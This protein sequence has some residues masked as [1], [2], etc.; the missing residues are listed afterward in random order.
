MKKQKL[1]KYKK[2]D[3]WHL[4]VLHFQQQEIDREKK[5]LGIWEHGQFLCRGGGGG[6]GFISSKIQSQTH[7][8][9]Q[10]LD[11]VMTN[12]RDLNLNPTYDSTSGPRSHAGSNKVL[13]FAHDKRIVHHS[14]EKFFFLITLKIVLEEEMTILSAVHPIICQFCQTPWN[15]Q[16]FDQ[17]YPCQQTH[18][19]IRGLWR[20]FFSLNSFNEGKLMLVDVYIPVMI[21]TI[22]KW[23]DWSRRDLQVLLLSE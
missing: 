8:G 12:G 11:A 17:H 9:W 15:R 21:F 19:P 3:I 16:Y 6:G 5:T 2:K 10:V 22:V 7:C 14:R 13:S 18:F 1:N 20:Q 4:P 23:I